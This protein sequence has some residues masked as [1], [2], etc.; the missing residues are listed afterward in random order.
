M[1]HCWAMQ[2]RFLLSFILLAVSGGSVSAQMQVPGNL[3]LFLLVGQSNMA[4]RGSVEDTDRVPIPGVFMFNKE[5]AWTPAVDPIHFDRPERIGVG[6]G[7][8]FA[9]TLL[10]NNPKAA[11]GLI[12]AA[13]GGSSLAQWAPQGE[14]F[15]D[16]VRRAKAARKSGVLR[17]ILWHQGESDSA[18]EADA[19][20][21]RDRWTKIINALRQELGATDVPVVVGQLGE[22]LLP[23]R[24][25][26][27]LVN[28]QLAT[29]P[30]TV[31]LTAF[32]SSARLADQG[33]RIH[34]D[35]AAYREFGRR[36][37]LAFLSLDSSW[38][39]ERSPKTH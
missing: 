23:D 27:G 13:M 39:A 21:Y 28:E 34:F 35:S 1:V 31:P 3:Q 18:Q 26:S 29:I 6:M 20:S 36:Y 15:G 16:A 30:L 17:A 4:G 19:R 7:R 11:I 14:L 9:L 5:L 10:E 37:A 32:V 33:D 12:P 24:P 8:S 22:F 2:P 38:A 25:L